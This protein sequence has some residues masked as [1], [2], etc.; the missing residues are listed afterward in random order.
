MGNGSSIRRRH[1]RGALL[2]TVGMV[3][4]AV[5]VTVSGW[6]GAEAAEREARSDGLAALS[7][8]R[9]G[10]V[11][12]A[13][14]RLRDAVD[15]T[16][17]GEPV[18]SGLDVRVDSVVVR[19]SRRAA[20]TAELEAVAELDRQEAE[21]A[22]RRL[23]TVSVRPGDRVGAHRS[24]ARM[25]RRE[26]RAADSR[27][28]LEQALE[29]EDAPARERLLARYE[30]AR[31]S[32]DPLAAATLID[33][34][35]A[36]AFGEV[37]VRDRVAVLHG[38]EAPRE[39]RIQFEAVQAT[40]GDGPILVDG[41]TLAWG[42]PPSRSTARVALVRWP[43]AAA[44]LVPGLADGTFVL[45]DDATGGGT[46]LPAPFPGGHV[47]DSD[48]S[49]QAVAAAARRESAPARWTSVALGVVLLAGAGL[50][51]RQERARAALERRRDDFLCAVT[52]ELKTPIA[53]V[54]LYAET[55]RRHGEEDPASVPGFAGVVA[56]EALRLDA[57]VQELLD[58]AAGRREP[59]RADADGSL[60]VAAVAAE[61]AQEFEPR[62]RA[63]GVTFVSKSPDDPVWAMGD[64][65]LVRRALGALVENALHFG[66]AQVEVRV[67]ADVQQVVVD[68]QDDGDG[69]PASERER[70]FEPFERLD[71]AKLRAVPGTGLGL[72]LARR[73]V[74][75]CGGTLD[76][77]DD[78]DGRGGTTMRMVLRRGG[79]AESR[80]T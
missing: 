48:A 3:L 66:G 80:V 39:V 24:L 23:A 78:V 44:Q 45:T 7:L 56:T 74:E 20:P 29:I 79:P 36:G 55:L 2:G 63:A 10:E 35:A 9:R 18:E 47:V 12:T 40:H 41:S 5:A 25:F 11:A 34:L 58:V 73:C 64:P 52:H 31:S 59:V 14:A 43:A 6:I 42:L 75:R 67:T 54:L 76:C 17:S 61:V 8:R 15:A 57:R 37:G 53:N 70:V 26:G 46:P 51:L 28:E 22:Y 68:V 65:T 49:T 60:D 19:A 30:L 32:D 16:R 50:V 21:A 72:P 71:V 33:E 1:G 69:I 62:F 4:A 13:A 27:A 77:V 38:L